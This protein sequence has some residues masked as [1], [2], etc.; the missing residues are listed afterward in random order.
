[1]ALSLDKL[2]KVEYN[3]IMWIIID[4]FGGPDM[5]VVATNEEGENLLF[6]SKEEADEFIDNELQTG[7]AVEVK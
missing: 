6:N 5:A 7:F 2:T 1:M 4:T 3:L